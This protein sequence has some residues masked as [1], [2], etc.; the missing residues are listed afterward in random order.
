MALMT[1]VSITDERRLCIS[2]SGGETSAFM[3]YWLLENAK[4]QYDKIVVLFANTGE[5]REETLEFVAACDAHFGFNTVW[6]E[7]VQFHGERKGPSFKVVDFLTA[8]RNGEPFEEYIRKY[9]IPNTKYKDCTRGLKRYPIEAYLRDLGWKRNTYDLAIGIRADE[10]DRISS[11]ASR[12]LI[13]PLVSTVKMTKPKVNSW[14]AAQSFRLRLKG[15]EGNCKWCWKK[16]FRKHYTILNEHPE[17]YDF[18]ER[19]E[20]TY[21]LVG[22]EFKKDTI[23]DDYCRTFFRGNKSVKDLREEAAAKQ[24]TPAS[25]DHIVFDD[26]LDVGGGCEESCEVFADMEV[27]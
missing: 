11:D 10:I 13:Y 8:S 27:I 26:E 17:F 2:F 24:F 12:R 3:T 6:I 5:E 9:G 15:Y 20:A 4:D 19:M 14:W 25:D 16:S 18:P 23:P 7:A 1:D 22:P 21:G